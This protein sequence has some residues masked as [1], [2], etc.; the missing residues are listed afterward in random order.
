MCPEGCCTQINST[1]ETILEQ[2]ILDDIHLEI[3]RRIRNKKVPSLTKKIIV[4]SL[5]RIQDLHNQRC[6]LHEELLIT[7]QKKVQIRNIKNQI[8]MEMKEKAREFQLRQMIRNYDFK[9]SVTQQ[10]VDDFSRKMGFFFGVNNFTNDAKETV[11]SRQLHD[12]LQPD[13]AGPSL[14]TV[15]E[16]EAFTDHEKKTKN[17]KEDNRE[18]G[19][20]G[21]KSIWE[22]VG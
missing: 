17:I 4:H 11:D 6:K 8:N 18:C 22:K 5:I 2:R 9:E 10:L 7:V 16:K 19:E 1:I 20:M 12:K 14:Q 3:L 13:N 21:P 15:V